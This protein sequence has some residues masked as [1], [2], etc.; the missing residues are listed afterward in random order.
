MAPL[1]KKLVIMSLIVVF[2]G[3][4]DTF[5]VTFLIDFLNKIISNNSN[6]IL[7]QTQL[8]T[9]YVFIAILAVPAFGMQIPLIRLS[10]AIGTIFIIFSGV[11]IS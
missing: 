2:F 7:L 8:F 4:W 9:G 6:N 1:N 3:F 5:V 11:C 10:K